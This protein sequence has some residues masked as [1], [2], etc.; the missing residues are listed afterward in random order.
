MG[1]VHHRLRGVHCPASRTPDRTAEGIKIASIF[2]SRSCSSLVSCARSTELRVLASSRD[3]VAQKFIDDAAGGG[4]QH[5]RQ[6]AAPGSEEC[7]D[8]LR[9]RGR[10][11]I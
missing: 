2:I 1:V 5:H 6:P 11:I 10:R 4:N 7:E 8:K 3:P 9:G